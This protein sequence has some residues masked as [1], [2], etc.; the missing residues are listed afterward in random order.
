M[1]PFE[2]TLL[3]IVVG[4]FVPAYISLF[5]IKAVNPLPRYL[6][7]FAFG[8]LFWSFSDTIGASSYLDVN[9][10]FSGGIAH[11]SLVA[12]F[13]LAL[14]VFFALHRESPRQVKEGEWSASSSSVAIPVLVALA[15]S[16]HGFGEGVEVGALSSSTSSISMID[17]FG[18]YGPAI[19][20]VLHKALEAI[21]IGASYYAYSHSRK[22]EEEGGGTSAS[23]DMALLGGIFAFPS[24]VGTALGY[25]FPFDVTY[26]FA[27]AAGASIYVATRLAKPLFQATEGPTNKWDSL[28]MA[29]LILFGFFSIYF[30]ALFHS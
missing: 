13:A 10:G 16:I 3:S 5:G 7:A 15:L 22:G 20:Y 9:S 21:L 8:I 30:A 27:L 17:A 1:I 12:L 4:T 23:K 19:S 24:V 14:F 29:L 28:K 6:S 25:Y 26:V 18:G 2:V 11:A